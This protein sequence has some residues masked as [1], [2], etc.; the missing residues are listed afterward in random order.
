MARKS[1][2]ATSCPRTSA[3]A[4]PI[5]PM[6]LAM[7]KLAASFTALACSARSPKRQVFAPITSSNAC[8]WSMACAGPAASRL[9]LPAAATSG[10]PSTG[11]AR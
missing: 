2:G 8:T 1:A 6:A 9:S 3:A 5:V 10:R 4:S 7:Q 11:T